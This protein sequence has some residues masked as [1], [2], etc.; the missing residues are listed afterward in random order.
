MAYQ[1]YWEEKGLYRVFTGFV[2]GEEVLNSNLDLHGD[3]R[4]DDIRYVLN[5]FSSIE[6]F[7]VHD[8]DIKLIASTDNAASMSKPFLKIAVVAKNKD[9]IGWVEE[10]LKR[11]TDVSYD[12]HLFNDIDVARNWL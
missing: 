1:N 8:I 10:Y 12:C 11:M 4:F 5:D 3:R 2:S 9:L 7:H 6:D